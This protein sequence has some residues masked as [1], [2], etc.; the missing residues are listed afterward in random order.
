[1]QEFRLSS[2]KQIKV[3]FGEEEFVVRKPKVS[4]TL[5]LT[6]AL[7]EVKDGTLEQTKTMIEWLDS[8]GLP[9]R[10]V[11]EMYQTELMELVDKFLT[12]QPSKKN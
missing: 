12:D 4:D 10:V 2:E 9:E 3:I 1:M 7:K 8:L 5:R 6:E 11:G